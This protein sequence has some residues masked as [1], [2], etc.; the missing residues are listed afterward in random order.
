MLKLAP[1][2]ASFDHAYTH[3]IA[4]FAF[5]NGLTFEQFGCK[6]KSASPARLMTHWKRLTRFPPVSVDSFCCLVHRFY[7]DIDQ[8]HAFWQF[9]QLATVKPDR[10]VK[11]LNFKKHTEKYV[12]CMG[13]GKTSA[14]IKYLKRKQFIWIQFLQQLD[15]DGIKVV[16]GS[17]THPP[18]PPP[19]RGEWSCSEVP[20]T[21]QLRNGGS[22]LVASTHPHGP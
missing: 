10:L 11:K 1:L 3:R 17:K 4:R 15:P 14:T 22:E 13:F 9:K 18:L 16:L 8:D 19:Q 20:T 7:P 21:K 6:Q 2:D 5:S 12:L